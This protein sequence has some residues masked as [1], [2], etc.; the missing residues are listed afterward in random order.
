MEGIERRGG[1]GLGQLRNPRLK[2]GI[3]RGLGLMVIQLALLACA[4][5][6]ELQL[7]RDG[8][9]SLETR[10]TIPL[11]VDQRLRALSGSDASQTGLSFFDP[12]AISQ[13]MRERQFQVLRSSLPSLQQY[14]GRFSINDL[15]SLASED[16]VLSGTDWI[17]LSSGNGWRELR[18]HINKQN[19]QDLV[20]LFP[21]IDRQLLE[22]LSPP[23]LFDLPLGRDD[24]R[25]MLA[26]LLGRQ[27]MD[28][29]DQAR[30][31]LRIDTPGAILEAEGGEIRKAT[32]FHF[33]LGLIDAMVLE[34]P[35][36]IRL[37]W[38]D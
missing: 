20:D 30:F 31:S 5:E 2:A 11:A 8:S 34:Q 9:A 12:E 4:T 27:A 7:H 36:F 23:A 37:R 33:S 21:G 35:V 15:A 18:M 13:G 26:A 19:A 24:Y 38:R 1:T 3:A 16:A 10:F 32:G 28:A 29:L 25:S 6:A 17:A 22:A 14:H